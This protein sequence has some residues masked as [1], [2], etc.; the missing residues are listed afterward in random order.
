MAE[1][2]GHALI[3]GAL[4]LNV[5]GDREVGRHLLVDA[6]IGLENRVEVRAARGVEEVVDLVLEH[7]LG[8]HGEDGHV[9]CSCV[10][11]STET[12]PIQFSRISQPSESR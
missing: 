3:L 1:A 8:E 12:N 6:L 10:M 4:D 2:L 11:L 7:V 5:E 9:G